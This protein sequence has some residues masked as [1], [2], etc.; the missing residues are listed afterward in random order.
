MLAHVF[1]LSRGIGLDNF[2]TFWLPLG[3]A[4]LL[5]LLATLYSEEKWVVLL[6]LAFATSLHLVL[7]VGQVGGYPPTGDPVYGYQILRQTLETHSWIFGSGTRQAQIYSYFPFM[8]VFAALWSGIGAIP[9][10]LIVQYAFAFVNIVSL[11]T[12]RM[13][14]TDLLNLSER[15]VNLV[16]FFYTLTPTIHRVEAVFHYEAY[17][18]IFFSLVILYA[19]KPKISLSE[20]TVAVICIISI[21]FSHYFTAYILLLDAI[22]LALAYLVFRGTQIHI[23]L[24]FMSIVAPLGLIS[25]ISVLIFGRQVLQVENVLS[26][27]RSLNTLFTKISAAAAEPVATYYP[28]T[29]FLYLT[30]A[31]NVILLLLGLFA[32]CVLCLSRVRTFRI[33]IARRDAFTYLGAVWLFSVV[34]SV[35]AY[36]GVAWSESVLATSGAGAASNRIAEFSFFYFAVFG[37]L[38]IY[39]LFQKL[40]GRLRGNITKVILSVFLIVIFVS[41]TVVQ[42]YPRITYESSYVPT[43]Y[44]EYP[45]AFQE[46]YYLGTWWN[47]A[48]NHTLTNTRPVTGSR[49]LHDDLQG[50]GYQYLWFDQLN[51]SAVDLNNTKSQYFV[52]Y[53]AIDLRNLQ[54]PEHLYNNTLS[55]AL[56]S[57]HNAHLNQIFSTGRILYVYKPAVSP[58][59]RF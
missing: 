4:A 1:L 31:R 35:A 27:V 14:G 19:L 45:A 18:S 30:S 6:I 25:S 36:Y 58:Q 43:Y 46:P 50:Y 16:L 33:R 52:V 3:S 54:K 34:F 15:P 56:V 59:R 44:D 28:S 26:N 55:P 11:L 21:A 8:F 38:G 29:Q 5:I 57:S 12:L 23:D 39:L 10:F 47:A 20:R 22:V 40:N 53:Y 7:A 9:P 37:G 13:V 48:A 51:E 24:L 17:A 49:A 42:A 2:M 41:C 32:I